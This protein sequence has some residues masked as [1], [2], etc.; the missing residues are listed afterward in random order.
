MIGRE[1][2]IDHQIDSAPS[3]LERVLTF[4][5][6]LSQAFDLE[7]RRRHNQTMNRQ[8]MAPLLA[9]HGSERVFSETNAQQRIAGEK[10]ADNLFNV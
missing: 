2:E 1:I 5:A 8:K 9:P 6:G 7:H 4:L 3:R 10:D